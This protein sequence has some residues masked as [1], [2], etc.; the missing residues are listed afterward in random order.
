M[1][2]VENCPD[3]PTVNSLTFLLIIFSLNQLNAK[4]GIKCLMTDHYHKDCMNSFSD[5]SI[6][7]IIYVELGDIKKSKL[8]KLSIQCY[9]VKPHCLH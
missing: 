4:F 5:H 1:I 8:Y 2:W 7:T 6:Y 3:S 9:C